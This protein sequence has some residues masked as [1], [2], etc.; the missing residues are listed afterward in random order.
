MTLDDLEAL[1]NRMF[2]AISGCISE[3]LRDRAKVTINH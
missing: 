2:Q 3:T 1:W